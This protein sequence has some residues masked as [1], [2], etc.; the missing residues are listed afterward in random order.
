MCL[1]NFYVTEV[2]MDLPPAYQNGQ[3]LIFNY[4]GT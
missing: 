3:T 2:E 1:I 4:E